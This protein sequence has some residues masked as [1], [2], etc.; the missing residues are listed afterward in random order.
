MNLTVH[1]FK[2][3][4]KLL[5]RPEQ[6]FTFSILQFSVWEDTVTKQALQ[7]CVSRINTKASAQII[8]SVRHVG[9]RIFNE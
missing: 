2:L 1:E 4:Y 5:L 7:K 9:Y 3:L 8:E 6:T